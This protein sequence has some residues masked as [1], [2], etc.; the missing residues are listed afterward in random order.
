MRVSY[1]ATAGLLLVFP[2]AAGFAQN[3]DD[4]AALVNGNVPE[5]CAVAPPSLLTETSPINIS[6]LSGTALTITQ[7]TD[8]ATLSTKAASFKVG[9]GAMCNYPHQ[10]VIQSLNNGLWRDINTVPPPGFANAISYSA[11]LEW[12]EVVA[13]FQA[14]ASTRRIADLSVAVANPTQGQIELRVRILP[15][16]TN[17][18]SFAPLLSGVYRD[19]I[20]L[21]VGPQ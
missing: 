17:T 8:P 18:Q 5:F 21:T 14:D 7:L 10:I 15:G 1:L 16:A 11:T 12:G 6:G 19:T 3:S 9:F 4:G 13:T 20:R 2:A